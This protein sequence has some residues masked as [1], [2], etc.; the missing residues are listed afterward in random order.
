MHTHIQTHT[1]VHS[2]IKSVRFYAQFCF[3]LPRTNSCM[4]EELSKFNSCSLEK[5]IWH[6][7]LE[8]SWI[9]EKDY[10]HHDNS[11]WVSK[12]YDCC[13]MSCKL[14]NEWHGQ[15]QQ[16]RWIL[17][18]SKIHD[19]YFYFVCLPKF[20]PISLSRALDL[21]QAVKLLPHVVNS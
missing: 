6:E 19:G 4:G 18:S 8:T 3:F 9:S 14:C 20:F 15:L 16:R 13:T 7:D 5:G 2:H 10:R 17:A 11:G 1:Q 21:I 12:C